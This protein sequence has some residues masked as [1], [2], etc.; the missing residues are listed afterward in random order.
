MLKSILVLLACL[1]SLAASA[2]ASQEEGALYRLVPDLFIS[3]SFAHD[4]GEMLESVT[5]QGRKFSPQEATKMILPSL[6]W[7][8]RPDKLELG[9][10]WA[11]VIGLHG[12]EVL[13]QGHYLQRREHRE[14]LAEVLPNGTFRLTVW[15]VDLSGRE[16]GGIS[17]KQVDISSDFVM[18]VTDL[19]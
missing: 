17:H 15:V 14:P 19:P 16:P 7:N 9:T 2:P 4:Y 1:T 12:F 5:Y 11:K 8:T 10:A 6:G 3:T 18:T 13:Q